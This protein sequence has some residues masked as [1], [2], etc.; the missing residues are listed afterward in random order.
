MTV[1]KMAL[2]TVVQCAIIGL[3]CVAIVNIILGVY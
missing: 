1:F 2:I 3:A